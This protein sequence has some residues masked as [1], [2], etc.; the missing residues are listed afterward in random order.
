MRIK[1]GRCS[2]NVPHYCQP[3]AL[4]VRKSSGPVFSEYCGNAE[5][6]QAQSIVHVWRSF[7][8][9]MRSGCA[10]RGHACTTLL[11]FALRLYHALSAYGLCGDRRRFFYRMFKIL[12][13]TFGET[14]AHTKFLGACGVSTVYLQF[15]RTPCERSSI[16]GQWDRSIM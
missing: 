3:Y 5:H 16:A 8:Y 12:W 9:E 2:G 11:A 15:F 4:Y 13:C 6:S 1:I 14:T 10:H 7:A